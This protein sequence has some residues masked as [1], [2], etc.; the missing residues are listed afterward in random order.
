MAAVLALGFITTARCIQKKCLD[1][2][3][4]LLATLF[5]QVLHTSHPEYRKK[6]GKWTPTRPR[7]LW[8]GRRTSC[9]VECVSICR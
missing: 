7:T 1:S 4:T 8:H 2:G 5:N 3:R 6:G 9:H